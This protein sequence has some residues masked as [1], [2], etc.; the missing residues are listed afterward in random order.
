MGANSG[1]CMSLDSSAAYEALHVKGWH[2]STLGKKDFSVDLNSHTHCIGE[3]ARSRQTYLM[4]DSLYTRQ[5][6][7]CDMFT[8]QKFLKE[9]GRYT[10]G[11]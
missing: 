11:V 6:T 3:C 5:S 1:P 7:A 8:H 10:T 9:S 2:A 4:P